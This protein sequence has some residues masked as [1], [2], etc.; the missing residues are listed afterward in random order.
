MANPGGA[1]AVRDTKQNGT[2]P[3]LR[4]SPAAWREF[5]DQARRS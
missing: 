1:V 5:A 3:V 4:F 2:G